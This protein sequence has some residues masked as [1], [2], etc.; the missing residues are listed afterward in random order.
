MAKISH[1][2]SISTL[3]MS[4]NS[5]PTADPKEN[6]G[7]KASWVTVT[8]ELAMKWLDETNTKNRKVRQA[9]VDNM[10]SDML[11]GKWRGKNGEAI[12]FDTDGRL[13][14]G[15]H[16][17]YACIQAELPFDTLLV[18]G[19]DPEDYNSIGIGARKS[20]GDFLGPVHGEKNVAL[21][22]A[23]VRL[24]FAWRSGN[25]VVGQFQKEGD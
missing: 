2:R 14:D 18:I 7:P 12:R 8:P 24:V 20:F 16:R 15:Q 1:V 4:Y 22:A 3:P 13:V 23:T 21:Y 17:L 11:A 6:S 25:L 5:P 19:V 10:A 9:H